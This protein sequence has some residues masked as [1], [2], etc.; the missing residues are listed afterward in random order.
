MF[1]KCLLENLDCLPGDAR[2]MVG[3]LTYDSSLHFYNLNVSEKLHG[4]ITVSIVLQAHVNFLYVSLFPLYS[5]RISLSLRCWSS[6][7]LMVGQYHCCAG[8]FWQL[9]FL[10]FNMG[11]P[12]LGFLFA[13]PPLNFG[14]RCSPPLERNPEINTGCA[15]IRNTVRL[16]IYWVYM[17]VLYCLICVNI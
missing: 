2:T 16:C 1:C 3:I 7:T 5:S 11:L 14:T 10:I 8:L 9:A 15:C 4:V 17:Y 12:S 6:Q 13:P